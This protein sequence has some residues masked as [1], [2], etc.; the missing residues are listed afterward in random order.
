MNSNGLR[1][2][3]ARLIFVLV[4]GNV[5]L[6]FTEAVYARMGTFLDIGGPTGIAALGLLHQHMGKSIGWNIAGAFSPI[7]IGG[8]PYGY[9]VLS[10]RVLLAGAG[11]ITVARQWFVEP[12][13]AGTLYLW[14]VGG[15]AEK[16]PPKKGV[17]VMAFGY[18]GYAFE[19]VQISAGPIFILW[20]KGW[21]MAPWAGLR[22][23]VFL[24]QQTDEPKQERL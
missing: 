19:R 22:I 18:G 23:T 11:H 14:L 24:N 1:K 4:I 8:N 21:L 17:A 13:L 10:P 9:R 15:R 3:A 16:Y 6:T 2:G 7:G 20:D 5:F 12:G